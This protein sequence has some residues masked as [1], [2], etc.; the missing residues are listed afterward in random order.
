MP[1]NFYGI[2]WVKSFK[3]I[4][5]FLKSAPNRVDCFIKTS[6]HFAAARWPDVV[7]GL[8]GIEVGNPVVERFRAFVGNVN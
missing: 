7:G 6:V 3:S 5:L 4:N 8:G 2:G 1:S